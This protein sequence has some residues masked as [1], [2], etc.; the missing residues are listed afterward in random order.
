[1]YSPYSLT[2][3]SYI[4]LSSAVFHWLLL[5]ICLLIILAF[6]VVQSRQWSYKVTNDLVNH[7]TYVTCDL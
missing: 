1:M 7:V 2:S 6:N 5:L 4:G 3:D